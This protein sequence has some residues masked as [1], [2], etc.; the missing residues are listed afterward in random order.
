MN[1]SSFVAI[2]LRASA[3]L[4]LTL[5]VSFALRRASASVRRCVLLLGL[6]GSLLLPL[7]AFSFPVQSAVHVPA[8]TVAIRVV[9]EALSGRDGVTPMR[10]DRM[11]HEAREF[12]RA[13]WRE[14]WLTELWALGALI[15]LA[16]LGIAHLAA[17]RVARRSEPAGGVRYSAWL[18]SPVVIGV[19]R[20]LIVLPSVARAWG[21]ERIKAVLLHESAHVRRRDG[22]ALL[23]AHL[24]CAVYWF[25]PLGW[26][27]LRALRRECELAADED[28]IA[29][30]LRP[31]SYAE[32]LLA[33]ARGVAVPAVGI[34]MAARPSELARRITALVTR[35]RLPAPLTRGRT[36]VLAG[37]ALLVLVL[38][39]C[40]DAAQPVI[41]SASNATQAQPKA[42]DARLQGIAEDEARRVRAEWG[43]KRV[44][45]VVLDPK[46][47]ALVATSDDAPGQ[48]IVPASTLK[49]LTVAMALDGA[50]ITPEQRFDCGHGARAYGSEQ[51]RDAGEYGS[52]DASEILAVSSNV[53]VSRIF[54]TLG[55]QRLGE[56]LRR[57][58]VGAPSSIPDGTLRG[59]IIAIG[60]G[61]TTTPFAMAA[62]YGVFANDGLYVAP[63]ASAP[64][65]VI[66]EATARAVRSMLEGVVTGE[67]ATG[68]AASVPGV[69]VGGKTGTSDDP[70]CVQCAQGPGT[71][72]SF[73]GIVPL[74]QPR[75]VIY[76]GVGQPVK[77]GSGGTIAAPVFARIASRA[78]ALN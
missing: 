76:V 68:K 74:D 59:A 43:A 13:P 61:S 8:P 40:T 49:P 47:G 69:R 15:V 19:F 24:A 46:T 26:L 11:K 78:L 32:H 60:E 44:A 53:G 37:S 20:P 65:R 31:S 30:G 73:V 25:Q 6:A 4:A 10:L 35:E 57:F 12:G 29:S 77:E 42:T 5:V 28:V 23:V 17:R 75:W 55:G 71:F 51:L 45:I 63:G 48:P 41:S 18:E 16:R 27:A 50:L 66:K 2:G 34:A 14:V 72:A 39:A 70:D 7:A 9:A 58:H 3:V 33:I 54:D 21:E 1:F 56:G 67:R 64:E 62:A 22:L 36:F 38:V 52:L